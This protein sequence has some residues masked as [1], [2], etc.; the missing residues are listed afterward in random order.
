MPE[1]GYSMQPKNN[2][3]YAKAQ[4]YD[5]DASF[6]D[7]GMV[8]ANIKNK[9]TSEA[10]EFLKKA[11][12]M[13]VPVRFYKHNTKLGH[14]RELGGKKGR[15]P[16]KSAKIVLGVLQNAVANAANK[17]LLGELVVVHAAANKQSSY[18]RTAPRGRWRRSNFE[19]ARVEIVVKE[20]KAASEEDRKKKLEERKKKA[21]EKKARKKELEEEME[22]EESPEEMKAEE[23][24]EE[25]A[26]EEKKEA[27]KEAK[28][29]APAK[30]A[31][32]KKAAPKKAEA[33]KP[34]VK[35]EEKKPEVKKEEK[36]PEKKAEPVA[37]KKS[38]VKE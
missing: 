31:E 16:R 6:K 33:P 14:R 17:G 12:K 23:A 30:K 25:P 8:C 18:P 27:K 35:K 3:K 34:E 38:D 22:G 13:E 7:L 29:E 37:E 1:Y 2:V 28:A 19:T 32:P 26:P 20:C 11:A 24:P 15:Y 10:E 9:K 4:L 5:I 21:E 36:A